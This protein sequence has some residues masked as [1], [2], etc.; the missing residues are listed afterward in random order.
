MDSLDYWRLCDEVSVVDAA[1]LIVGEEPSVQREYNERWDADKRPL[2][3]DAAKTAIGNAILGGRLAATIRR[4]AHER[5]YDEEP[6]QSEGKRKDGIKT[7]IYQNEPNWCMTTVKVEDLKAWLLSRGFKTGFFFA[8]HID[9]PSYL[10]TAHP[11]YAPKLAAAVDAWQAIASDEALLNGK[12]PK[13]A[14]EKW[15]R[16]NAS[17]FGLSDDDG[18]PNKDG[19]EQIS[20]VANW[21][22]E[23]GAAKTRG[24]P[25]TPKKTNKN[26]DF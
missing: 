3:Y 23:G 12:T 14:I 6:R 21:R 4:D 17:R 2:G 22:P 25:P 18:N 5:G 13:Q 20:K 10:D 11:C 7:I 15:L 8:D 26:A 9:A 16:E 19:I 1:L 24:N